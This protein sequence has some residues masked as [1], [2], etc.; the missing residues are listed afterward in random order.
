MMIQ[1]ILLGYWLNYWK[2]FDVSP[3]KRDQDEASR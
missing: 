2:W 1:G 3:V